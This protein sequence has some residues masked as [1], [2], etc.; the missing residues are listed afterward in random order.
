MLADASIIIASPYCVCDDCVK[1]CLVG[2]AVRST[3]PPTGEPSNSK[4]P[5]ELIPNSFGTSSAPTNLIL[6]SLT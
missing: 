3:S 4:P 6:E 5:L 2:V 1:S